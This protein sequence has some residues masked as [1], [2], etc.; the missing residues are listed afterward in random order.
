[1]VFISG[2]SLILI[3]H[4]QTGDAPGWD[5]NTVTNCYITQDVVMM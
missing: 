2:N 4:K 5:S 1:M 3:I